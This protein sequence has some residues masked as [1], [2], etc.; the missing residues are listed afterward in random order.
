MG[1]ISKARATGVVKRVMIDLD[2]QAYERIEMI[3][4]FLGITRTE[5]TK[6]LMHAA[7]EIP[8]DNPI[9]QLARKERVRKVYLE[10]R[11]RRPKDEPVTA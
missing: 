1:T 5:V 11:C 9:W 2:A 10:K 3:A 8:L 7:S 6:R 4:A